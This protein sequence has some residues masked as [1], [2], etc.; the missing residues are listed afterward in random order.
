MQ[1]N[2]GTVHHVISMAACKRQQQQQ[3][4]MPG[5]TRKKHTEGH[6]I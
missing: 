4:H 6:V 3:Q 2:Y 1:T 5:S